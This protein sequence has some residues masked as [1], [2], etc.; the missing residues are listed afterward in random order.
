VAAVGECVHKLPHAPLLVG[1][2]F[3]IHAANCYNLLYGGEICNFVAEGEGAEVLDEEVRHGPCEPGA[4]VVVMVRM[5]IIIMILMLM[6]MMIIIIIKMIIIIKIITIITKT[7]TRTVPTCNQTQTPPHAQAGTAWAFRSH[8][9]QQS[10]HQAAA[11][12]QGRS[13]A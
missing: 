10:L 7:I 1:A 9:P 6:L 13:P 12:A 4:V 11:C 2:G 5:I 3:E 8:P